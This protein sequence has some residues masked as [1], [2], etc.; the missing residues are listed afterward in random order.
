MVETKYD[1]EVYYRLCDEAYE[2]LRLYYQDD[3]ALASA[4]IDL[5]MKRYDE[6]ETE[7]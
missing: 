4:A 5:A 6:M 3:Y 2:E 1:N 7:Q